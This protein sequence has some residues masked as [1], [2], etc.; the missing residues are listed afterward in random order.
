MEE[1]MGKGDLRMGK[2]G[3]WKKEINDVVCGIDGGIKRGKVGG[4]E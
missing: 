2:R 1:F 3:F 4:I